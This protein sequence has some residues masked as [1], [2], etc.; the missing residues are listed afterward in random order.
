MTMTTATATAIAATATTVTINT[1]RH[2]LE[3]FCPNH[4]NAESLD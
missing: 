4:K 2:L 1:M 3:K